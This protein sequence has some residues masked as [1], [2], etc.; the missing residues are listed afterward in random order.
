MGRQ[1]TSKLSTCIIINLLC[2]HLFAP[3]KISQ[4]PYL[5]NGDRL[6]EFYCTIGFRTLENEGV[7]HLKTQKKK[8]NFGG[9]TH[10]TLNPKPYQNLLQH[11]WQQPDLIH[12]RSVC[13]LLLFWLLCSGL[14]WFMG[15]MTS[16]SML[17]VSTLRGRET[18]Q[19]LG[20]STWAQ[21]QNIVQHGFRVYG[22]I[23]S[24]NVHLIKQKIIQNKLI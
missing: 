2:P 15:G 11:Q 6:K 13:R 1:V 10:V 12:S 17:P 7:V 16:R 3:P 14:W 19:N 22:N 21:V 9:N 4:P 8:P 5:P 23:F 18:F 24:E 20:D